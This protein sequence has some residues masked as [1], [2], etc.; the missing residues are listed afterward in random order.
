MEMN[1]ESRVL[2][3]DFLEEMAS[4]HTG[5]SVPFKKGMTSG[6]SIYCS[7][8]KLIFS[9][10]N[11]AAYLCTHFLQI[12]KFGIILSLWRCLLFLKQ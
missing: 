8:P 4:E 6:F 3:L 5:F 1:I 9:S 12:L 2:L 10:T 7:F 11:S